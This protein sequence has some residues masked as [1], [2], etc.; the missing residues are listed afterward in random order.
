MK[1]LRVC[2][3]V[4]VLWNGLS[5]ATT[6]CFA[7]EGAEAT[8]EGEASSSESTSDGE[9][10]VVD[11]L[12]TQVEEAIEVTSRRYLKAGVHTPWQI[13]HGILALR[14]GFLIKQG[15]EK[16]S[17]FDWATD[18]AKHQGLPLFEKTQ[19]GGRAHLYTQ[20][21]AFEG[22]PNQFQAIM[23]ML[24]LPNTQEFKT[25]TG[26]ITMADMV[27]NAQMDVNDE[28]ETA[29]TLW[30]LAAY[31]KPDAKWTNRHG[32]A[33][34]IER[35]VEI[36]NYENPA[37]QACGGCQCSVRLELRTQRLPPFR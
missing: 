25:K 36:Q 3:C 9:P 5:V 34:S 2:I 4:V 33:W 37:D 13:M 27:R 7:Q 15:A 23:T 32:Q 26:P 6:V 1:L 30:F 20:P 17:A 14:E 22:H 18:G 16:I 19:F 8:E 28:E 31:L 21:Y 12:L 29:W 24:R 10:D 11:P 35:L